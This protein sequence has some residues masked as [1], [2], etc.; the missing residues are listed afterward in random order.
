MSDQSGEYSC[1]FVIATSGPRKGWPCRVVRYAL[2]CSSFGVEE[3]HDIPNC[4][5]SC[6]VQRWLVRPIGVWNPLPQVAHMWIGVVCWLI[7]ALALHISFLFYG[8]SSVVFG[9]MG[10]AMNAVAPDWTVGS[11]VLLGLSVY[12]EIYRR[13]LEAVFESL[14]FGK[15]WP[16]LWL[17][18]MPASQSLKA[19]FSI[20]EDI[21]LNTVGARTQPCLH[22][23]RLG[24]NLAVHHHQGLGLTCPQGTGER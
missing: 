7:A 24:K 2:C 23:W 17:I 20:A 22:R 6:C 11:K 15:R 8:I 21:K 12:W 18:L 16:D 14:T 19:P 4:S 9:C 13:D 3:D 10:S 5:W 1:S